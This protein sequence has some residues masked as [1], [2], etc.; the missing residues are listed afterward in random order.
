M[1]HTIINK[2]ESELSFIR[3]D[4]PLST[5]ELDVHSIPRSYFGCDGIVEAVLQTFADKDTTMCAT[6]YIVEQNSMTFHEPT[7]SAF[8]GITG[9]YAIDILKELERKFKKLSIRARISDEIIFSVFHRRFHIQEG[10]VWLPSDALSWFAKKEVEDE[11]GDDDLEE[12]EIADDDDGFSAVSVLSD[13][14]KVQTAIRFR[15]ARSD[16]SISSIRATIEKKFG[17]PAGS[18]ALCGPD[19]K[20][21]RGDALIAT[22]RKR[23]E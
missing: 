11:W 4:L 22:L 20:H 21:L 16:A 10:Y 6:V 17:L 12:L 15:A 9:K 14:T 3:A 8:F 18:V 1:A 5:V 2:L 19:K 23:W 7:W 13:N